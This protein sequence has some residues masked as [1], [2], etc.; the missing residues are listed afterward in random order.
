MQTREQ[1]SRIYLIGPRG[2]GK[3]TLARLLADRLG[4]AW[5]DADAEL[6]RRAGRSIRD[7]F[8]TDGEATFRDLESAVLVELA[9]RDRHVLATGG[10]IILRPENRDLLKR[11]GWIVWLTADVT[12]LCQRLEGDAST[13]A[14]RPALTAAGSASSTEE[15]AAVLRQREPLYRACADFTVLTDRPPEMLVLDVLNAWQALALEATTRA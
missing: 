10:G 5:L 11:S 4:W 1:P 9:T 8:A 7:I 13:A 14:R 12:T 2:S 15:M 3:S 6:E